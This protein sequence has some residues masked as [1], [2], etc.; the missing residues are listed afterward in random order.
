L[1]EPAKSAEPPI[2]AESVLVKE[3][4]I[5][6]EAFLEARGCEFF[7]A[8]IF[9]FSKIDLKSEEK[10]FSIFFFFLL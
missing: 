9:S 7:R 4:K 6:S 1:F 3:V 2:K 5:F 10:Y 8:S